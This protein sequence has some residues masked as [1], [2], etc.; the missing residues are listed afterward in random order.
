MKLYFSGDSF[1]IHLEAK[2]YWKIGQQNMKTFV[3][4]VL[5]HVELQTQQTK[6]V[7]MRAKTIRRLQN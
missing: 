6:S 5:L 2:M 7:E 1:L 3:C 4:I